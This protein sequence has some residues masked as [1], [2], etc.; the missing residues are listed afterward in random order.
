VAI[1]PLISTA[2]MALRL[3]STMPIGPRL[4]SV[5]PRASKALD[6]LHINQSRQ[7]TLLDSTIT[8]YNCHKPRHIIPSY[9]EPRKGDLKE[10]EKELYNDQENNNNK[11]GNEEP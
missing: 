10:I 11:L 8:Y 3:P 4:D 2:P 5:A 7:A 1:A 6:N 9:L